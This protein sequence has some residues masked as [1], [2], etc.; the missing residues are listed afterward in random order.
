MSVPVVT[1][2][3]VKQVVKVRILP[4]D[5]QVAAVAATS[6]NVAA[7]GVERWGEVMRLHAAPT[8]TAS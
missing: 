1:V 3:G 5:E 2:A 8:L 7:R 6:D 4:T